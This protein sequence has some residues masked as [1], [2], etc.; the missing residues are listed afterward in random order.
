MHTKATTAQ[1]LPE[2]RIPAS[3]AR[4]QHLATIY[5]WQ[6]DTYRRICHKC[7]MELAVA[8]AGSG[9][10]AKGPHAVPDIPTI[11]VKSKQR[12][13]HYGH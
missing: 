2:S 5:H 6:P 1:H 7:S 11:R 12:D 10:A 9:A 3:E 13:G 8:S 4:S